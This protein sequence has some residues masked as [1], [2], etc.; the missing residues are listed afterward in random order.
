M[1]QEGHQK[2]MA[3]LPLWSRKDLGVG[4]LWDTAYVAV[5]SWA[6]LNPST[7]ASL[8]A[9]ESV[10]PK[11][12]NFPLTNCNFSPRSLKYNVFIVKKKKM[13]K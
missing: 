1:S 13:E 3:E 5:Q 8:R 9:G 6:E 4:G 11:H 7:V 2:G 10:T 12:P